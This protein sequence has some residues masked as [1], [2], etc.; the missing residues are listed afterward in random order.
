MDISNIQTGENIVVNSAEIPFDM[1]TCRQ[2]FNDTLEKAIRA[3]IT[4]EFKASLTYADMYAFFKKD[5]VAFNNVA[6][7]FLKSSDEERAHAFMF[8][9]YLNQRGGTN[10]FE[11]IPFDRVNYF[12]APENA[13]KMIYLAFVQ[14]LELEKKVNQ[15]ILNLHKLASDLNDPHFS[16][17]LEANFID[18]QV[19]SQH[20]LATYI[21]KAKRSIGMFQ[22]EMFDREFVL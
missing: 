22:Q 5:T 1:M 17:Y 20:Q 9:D 8:I 11:P 4:I 3:H 21:A 6:A 12:K 19:K 7:F 10:V 18:E 14:A 15:S 13:D 16:D 2:N